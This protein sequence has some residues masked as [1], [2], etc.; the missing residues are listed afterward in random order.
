MA[1]SLALACMGSARADQLSDMQAQVDALQRQIQELKA[2]IG[3]VQKQQEAAP[4]AAPGI[5]MKPGND[6][7]FNV[8]GGE[9][10]IYGHV[11]VSRR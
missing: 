10:T 7:T 3:S 11:D 5:S 8:G 4:T 6:L 1:C 9:V 2:Q